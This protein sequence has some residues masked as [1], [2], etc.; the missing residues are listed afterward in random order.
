MSMHV[1]RCGNRVGVVV[2]LTTTCSI[3]PS[4]ST[5]AHLFLILSVCLI[6]ISICL[7]VYGV[8][9]S[10]YL[11]FSYHLER[12]NAHVYKGSLLPT[13]LFSWFPSFLFRSPLL[14]ST[15]LISAINA[16]DINITNFHIYSYSITTFNRPISTRLLPDDQIQH[17]Q[18]HIYAWGA[19]FIAQLARHCELCSSTIIRQ[20]THTH[21]ISKIILCKHEE[22]VED[23]QALIG[24]RYSHRI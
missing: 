5:Q 18:N 17:V 13:S 16:I 8:Q 10:K 7:S 23:N 21:R 15:T 6:S 20:Q 2:N 14:I 4:L 3:V 22:R 19:L 12:N 9:M 1:A 11:G 24:G